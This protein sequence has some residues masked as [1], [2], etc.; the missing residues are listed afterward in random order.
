MS[1]QFPI[2]TIIFSSDSLHWWL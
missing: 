2:Y 1:G